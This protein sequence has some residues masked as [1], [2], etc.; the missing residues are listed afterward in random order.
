MDMDVDIALGWY[1][2]IKEMDIHNA[3]ERRLY[4]CVSIV[5][6]SREKNIA[7]VVH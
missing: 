7:I 5:E 2:G 6:P 4:S 1:M 3:W